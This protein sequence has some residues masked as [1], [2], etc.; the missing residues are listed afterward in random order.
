MQALGRWEGRTG[1]GKGE[2]NC[3]EADC[4]GNKATSLLSTKVYF[5]AKV[6]CPTLLWQS[7]ESNCPIHPLFRNPTPPCPGMRLTVP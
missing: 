5:V 3:F 1:Q 2:A 4:M 6:C 7:L